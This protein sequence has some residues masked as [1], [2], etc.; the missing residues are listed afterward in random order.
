[1]SLS[2]PLQAKAG[3]NRGLAHDAM[4]ILWSNDYSLEERF[5]PEAKAGGRFA[6]TKIFEHYEARCHN[7][8]ELFALAQPLSRNLVMQ[9]VASYKTLRQNISCNYVV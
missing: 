8:L 2:K 3:G 1:M 6:V 9:S 7:L 4:G 5:G